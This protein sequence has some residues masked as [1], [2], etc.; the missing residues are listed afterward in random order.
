M[1]GMI[2]EFNR[3]ERVYTW[4]DVVMLFDLPHMLSDWLVYMPFYPYV[5]KAKPTQYQ[6]YRLTGTKLC[7]SLLLGVGFRT[8]LIVSLFS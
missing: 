3:Y 7:F 4:M 2:C 1:F 8:G 5:P 6:P